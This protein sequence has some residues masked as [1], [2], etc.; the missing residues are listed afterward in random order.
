MVVFRVVLL[1]KKLIY[2]FD[3]AIR[4]SMCHKPQLLTILCV[5]LPPPPTR[6][7][8]GGSSTI[9]LKMEI[10]TQFLGFVDNWFQFAAAYQPQRTVIPPLVYKTNTVPLEQINNVVILRKNIFHPGDH[11]LLICF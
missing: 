9:L 8:F 5:W 10:D 2:F 1:Y 4:Q 3:C 11:L 6:C 7:S